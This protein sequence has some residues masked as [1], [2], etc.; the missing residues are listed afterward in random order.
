LKIT[1]NVAGN[2]S[3]KEIDGNNRSVLYLGGTDGNG[4]PLLAAYNG[5]AYESFADLTNNTSPNVTFPDGDSVLALATDADG[6]LYFGGKFAD[7]QNSQTQAETVLNNI[8]AWNGSDFVALNNNIK[9]GVDDTV[10]ALSYD[11]GSNV[12]YLGGDFND[13]SS[14]PMNYVASIKDATI[15]LFDPDDNAFKY[16]TS[17]VY[18]LANDGGANVF[19]GTG[20]LSQYYSNP[21]SVVKAEVDR[22][23]PFDNTFEKQL[24]HGTIGATALDLYGSMLYAASNEHSFNIQYY[25][26]P[27]WEPLLEET[28]YVPEP[29]IP[30]GSVYSILRMGGLIFVGGDFSS[31]EFN[32]YF[33]IPNTASFAILDDTHYY[34][35]GKWLSNTS[36]KSSSG[37]PIVYS[38][39]GDYTNR[40][41]YIAG[42]F[43]SID[44]GITADNLA[45]YDTVHN[46]FVGVSNSPFVNGAVKA[47][48]IGS[49]VN[50]SNI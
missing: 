12:L 49:V 17:P 36:V 18:A 34:F 22:N 9:V 1:Y 26:G 25:R 42:H 50:V 48:A 20:N 8:G 41:V 31:I 33:Y 32:D 27:E 46:S 30:D 38:I 43:D 37:D 24:S 23:N 5:F 14:L 44:N 6:T 2:N 21:N 3:V 7:I 15:K 4:K 16:V 35:Q 29:Y 40:L 47:M 11:S 13:N 45:I 19:I 10:R 39:I 28:D